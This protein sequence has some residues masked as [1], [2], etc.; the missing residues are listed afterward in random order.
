MGRPRPGRVLRRARPVGSVLV[1]HDALDAPPPRA[2]ATGAPQ[3]LDAVRRGRPRSGARRQGQCLPDAPRRARRSGPGPL[4]AG[5]ARRGGARRRP[6]G[7]SKAPTVFVDPVSAKAIGTRAAAMSPLVQFAHD[8]HGG[9]F[10][11]RDGRPLVGWLGVGMGSWA[12]TGLVLW[13]PKPHLWKYAFPRAPHRQGPA[14]PTA[15]CTLPSASGASSSS[16]WSAHTGVG[17]AFPGD[18]ARRDRRRRRARLQPAHR[19]RG[20]ADARRAAHRRRRGG[21]RRARRGAGQRAPLGH[22]AGPQDP[23]DQRLRSPRRR[24]RRRSRRWSMS[25]PIAPR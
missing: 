23:G 25:I 10:L 16:S 7:R 14:L 11:G 4:P 20:R 6:P 3:S 13:W 17:I 24:G 21:P 2:T 15:S 9:L 5:P 12:S 18:A 22:A 8:L 1:Y 19:S